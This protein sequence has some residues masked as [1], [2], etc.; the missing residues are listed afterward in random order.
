MIPEGRQ[1]W[2]QKNPLRYAGRACAELFLR[3]H[4]RSDSRGTGVRS[5]E[6][7]RLQ[8]YF[9]VRGGDLLDDDLEFAGEARPASA[10]LGG[11]DERK[12]RL[13]DVSPLQ[14]AVGAADLD[15]GFLG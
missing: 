13:A 5:A 9:G 6:L 11:F 2:A 15:R 8:E 10:I 12:G 1:V 7:A 14:G 3:R 4:A